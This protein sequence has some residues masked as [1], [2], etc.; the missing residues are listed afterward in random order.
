MLQVLQDAAGVAVVAVAF[1]AA[2]VAV[3]AFVFVAAVVI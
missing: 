1:A 3:T 2:L